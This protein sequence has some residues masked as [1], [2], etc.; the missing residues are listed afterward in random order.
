MKIKKVTLLFCS[1]MLLNPLF[2]ASPYAADN[3]REPSVQSKTQGKDRFKGD[4]FDIEKIAKEINLSNE[5]KSK[6]K[7]EKTRH[8]ERI[9]NM[10][11]VLHNKRTELMNELDK[12]VSD[13]SKIDSITLA[14]KRTASDM[15]D[16]RLNS[17]LKVKEI[18]TP[19]QY[20]QFVEKK[21]IFINQKNYK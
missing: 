18:L 20:K 21:N 9:K 7:D 17:A 2:I 13:R 14:M 16:E 5:Q 4:F 8:H 3:T 19:E 15:I 10:Q 6:L 1:M 12:P 11:T